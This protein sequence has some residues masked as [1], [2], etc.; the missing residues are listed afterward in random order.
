M[1][2]CVG[3]L[4]KAM[5]WQRGHY[6]FLFKP[7]CQLR[8]R[9]DFPGLLALGDSWQFTAGGP[10]AGAIARG[11]GRAVNP[12]C[13]AS[14]RAADLAALGLSVV[15]KM[16]GPDRACENLS[17]PDGFTAGQGGRDC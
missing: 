15:S 5:R 11:G 7:P 1:A 16:A 4:R 12:C 2:T 10:T 8:L 14:V 13:V 9:A 3:L 17:A 6:V